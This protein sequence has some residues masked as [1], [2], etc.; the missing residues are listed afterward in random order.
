MTIVTQ[1]PGG[2][3]AHQALWKMA[4]PVSEFWISLPHEMVDGSPSPR[5]LM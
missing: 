1:R 4:P 5:K 3:I 2:M